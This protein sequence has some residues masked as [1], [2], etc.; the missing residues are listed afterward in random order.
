MYE[1]FNGFYANFCVV[2]MK[3]MLKSVLLKGM[4]TN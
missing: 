2:E 4:C 3:E 1:H